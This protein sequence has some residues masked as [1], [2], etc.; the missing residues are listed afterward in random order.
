MYAGFVDG[1]MDPFPLRSQFKVMPRT[2][3]AELRMAYWNSS[4]V[5]GTCSSLSANPL[6][7]RLTGTA[8]PSAVRVHPF[9]PTQ[10]VKD[11]KFNS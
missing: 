6:L 3:S 9:Q 1:V 5:C 7:G 11:T 8:V 10:F 4:S 2:K